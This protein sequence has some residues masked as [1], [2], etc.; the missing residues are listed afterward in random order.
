MVIHGLQKLT[1]LDFPGKLACTVFTAGCNLRCPFCHNARLV[2]HPEEADRLDEQ[3]VLTYIYSRKTMLDGV[4][5]TGGEPLL[6]KDIFGFIEKIKETGLLVK[7][8][9]NGCFPE[10]LRELI[11]AK[12]VDYVAMDIKNSPEE[13]GK[14]VGVENFDITPIKQSIEILRESGIEY[15]LRT[16]VV[17]ELHTR[18]SLLGAAEFIAP[19]KKWFLQSFVD[20]GDLI[21]GEFSAYDK[22]FMKELQESVSQIVE[23]VELRGV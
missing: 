20:S 22:Q 9:T 15:E 18:E 16:T 17:R 1:V 12:L 6:Q 11:D 21:E 19:Q 13:Y 14:T 23:N 4:C 2:T 5:I 7:L 3:E 8:D 10:K